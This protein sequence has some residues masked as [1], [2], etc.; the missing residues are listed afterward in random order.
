VCSSDLAAL[1]NQ[2]LNPNGQFA[3]RYRQN[4]AGVG[5]SGAE[6]HP[7]SNEYAFF[8][9]DDWR[10][11]AKLTLNAG[12]R[13]DYQALAQPPIQNPNAALLAAGF[14][15]SFKPSDKNNIAPRFG[16]SYA[17]N[18]KTVLRGGYGLFYART[19][20]IITGTA[21]SNNG[22]QVIG[23]DINCQTPPAGVACPLYP[24][25][26]S[27]LP[28]NGLAPINLYLFDPNYKQPFVHQGRVSFE[29]EILPN[30]SLSVSYTIYR[31][32]DLTRTRDANFN[33]PV[34]RPFTVAG[35]GETL[36]FGRFNITGVNP[37]PLTQFNR[38]SL[39]EST[40]ESFYQG[41][42]VEAKRR[43]ANHFSFIA[44]YTFSK[45]KDDKPDQTS[46]VVGTDD[47]KNVQNQFNVATEYG[48]SDLDLRHRFVFSPVYETGKFK[49]NENAVLQALLSNWV[50]SGILQF[51]SGFAY[52]AAVTGNP[53]NDDNTANDRVTGTE[54]NQ[55]STPATYQVDMRL[56]R[57]LKFGERYRLTILGEGFNIFNR[58][59]V[60]AVN[61]SFYTATF[62]NTTQ[63]GTL[64][65]TLTSNFPVFGQP[66]LFLTERQF[67]LG[68][69][70]EF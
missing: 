49:W 13:Y 51:Q 20:S 45:A 29:R 34:N 68:I 30:L 10:V 31:G 66:R 50:F 12:I 41:F 64:T 22:V 28:S 32:K 48:R 42:S 47:A 56:M 6:T 11:N 19:P 9:Q 4:F 8:F 35:T 25:V 53:N 5:T 40:A 59:N 38:I 36:P 7:D 69:K 1:S 55:F 15:T 27:S 61:N 63:T 3:T 67:Q 23:I 16:V 24:N 44:A 60:S 54:R 58:S 52:S 21:H 43:L 62:N 26:L 57:V 37:R 2:L 14:D 18:D 46:V 70:F 33:A 17:F 39:F 65:R